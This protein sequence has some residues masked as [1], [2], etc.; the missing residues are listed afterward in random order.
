MSSSLF[1]LIS[2]IDVYLL[3]GYCPRPRG[4][5]LWSPLENAGNRNC[6]KSSKAL[7]VDTITIRSHRLDVMPEARAGGQRAA[8]S[9]S[10][11]GTCL[12]DRW[13]YCAAVFGLLQRLL[14]P[15]TCG[16]PSRFKSRLHFRTHF[17]FPKMEPHLRVEAV[18]KRIAENIGRKITSFG[19]V[20]IDHWFGGP[21]TFVFG[22]PNPNPSIRDGL[23]ETYQV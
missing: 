18:P 14:P 10:T 12:T 5:T 13:M 4:D 8:T 7:L 20:K 1:V 3:D 23:N 19:S 16:N 6:E 21:K 17:F 11:P 22:F 9:Y 2:F 15:T